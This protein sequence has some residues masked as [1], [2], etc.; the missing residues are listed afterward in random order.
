ML[1]QAREI[2]SQWFQAGRIEGARNRVE[3]LASSAL[4]AQDDR[5][6]PNCGHLPRQTIINLPKRRRTSPGA[7][8][9][10]Q[11]E[12]LRYAEAGYGGNPTSEIQ[13]GTLSDL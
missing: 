3:Q 2:C 8:A 13:S 12:A 7:I 5:Y 11:T 6:P 1:A 10:P 4:K 9:Y